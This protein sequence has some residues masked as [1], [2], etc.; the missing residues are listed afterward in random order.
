MDF[1][2]PIE[3]KT[4]DYNHVQINDHFLTHFTCE[5]SKKIMIARDT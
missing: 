5:M 2:T 4:D 3:K 1:D